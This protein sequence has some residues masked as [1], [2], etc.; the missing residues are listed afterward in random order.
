MN[1]SELNKAIA[2]KLKRPIDDV[3][4]L[5]AAF[6][7]VVI[8]FCSNGDSVAIPRFGTIKSVSKKEYIA[9]GNDGKKYLYPPKISA[10]FAASNILKNKVKEA[11]NE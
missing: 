6:A 7:D 2:A 3:E 11:A 10:E 8:D 9:V 1:Q 5:S 4:K